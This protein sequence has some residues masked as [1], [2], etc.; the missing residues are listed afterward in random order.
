MPL[1]M[2]ARKLKNIDVDV[3]AFDHPLLNPSVS[4]GHAQAKPTCAT[5][6]DNFRQSFLNTS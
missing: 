3:V 1:S 2:A 4:T 6:V 5:P